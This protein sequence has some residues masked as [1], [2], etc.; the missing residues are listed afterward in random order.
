MLFNDPVSAAT[1]LRDLQWLS[2]MLSVYALPNYENLAPNFSNYELKRT[3]LD[4]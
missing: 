1:V 3:C 2:A 4:I